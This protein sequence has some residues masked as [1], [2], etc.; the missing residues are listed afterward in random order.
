MKKS[1]LTAL[2]SVILF[3]LLYVNPSICNAQDSINLKGSWKAVIKKD[4]IRFRFSNNSGN[5]ESDFLFRSSEFAG[6]PK[7]TSAFTV[8]RAAGIMNFE[9]SFENGGGSGTF[10]F[11]PD[12]EFTNFLETRGLTKISE[13]ES[14]V[15]FLSDFTKKHIRIL[16]EEGY[17][18]T[19][20]NLFSMASF[21]ID[22]DYI[23]FW[24]DHG[25]K[26]LV[27]SELIKLKALSISPAY[28]TS[29]KQLAFKCLSVNALAMIKAAG[30]TSENIMSMRKK[31]HNFQNPEDYINLKLMGKETGS[32]VADFLKR[33]S[34]YDKDSFQVGST[35]AVIALPIL[36]KLPKNLCITIKN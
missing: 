20:E 19:K 10:E 1:L 5:V 16:E 31:G 13:T 12:D 6:L 14:M 25:Y 35:K 7:S 17:Q 29:F 34:Q 9:G 11:K 27:F 4:S 23:K 26:S 28:I 32:E 8:N 30:L 3:G 21:N 36:D 22:A 15:F 18:V 33:D 2:R 24:K